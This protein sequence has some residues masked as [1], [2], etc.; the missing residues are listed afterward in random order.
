MNGIVDKRTE[1][2]RTR[3]R[4]DEID[5]RLRMAERTGDGAE[6]TE[7]RSEQTLLGARAADLDACIR[8][9]ELQARIVRTLPPWFG[10]ASLTDLE[11]AITVPEF[12]SVDTRASVL[13]LG[14][15]GTGKTAAAALV[16]RRALAV[17]PVSFAWFSAWQL[18]AAEKRHPLGSGRPKE[19]DAACTAAVLVLDDLGQEPTS[20]VLMEVLNERYEQGRVTIATSGLTPNELRTRYSDAIFR[21]LTETRGQRGTVIAAFKT[22]ARSAA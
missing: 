22:A 14:P 20:P 8:D 7:L 10:R 17:K 15:T 12:C 18:V 13:L 19:L 16:V 3:L 9:H 4:L 6:A 21:R 11:K 1:L 5:D 2:H